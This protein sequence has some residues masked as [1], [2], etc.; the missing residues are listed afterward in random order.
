MEPESSSLQRI[1]NFG[2]EGIGFRIRVVDGSSNHWA[3]GKTKSQNDFLSVDY[4]TMDSTGKALSLTTNGVQRFQFD[5]SSREKWAIFVSDGGVA[6]IQSQGDRFQFIQMVV[7]EPGIVSADSVR[8]E[9]PNEHTRNI[10]ESPIDNTTHQ[11]IPATL[12]IRK[13]Y[14]QVDR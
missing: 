12:V 2:A 4:A 5:I 3:W 8:K 13:I 1:R 9:A 6:P 7:V 11:R 14:F 10:D